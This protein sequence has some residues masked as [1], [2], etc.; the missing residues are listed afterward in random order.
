MKK[1][2]S[3]QDIHLL[4]GV[5]PPKEMTTYWIT[6]SKGE[7]QLMK[8]WTKDLKKDDSVYIGDEDKSW[9]IIEIFE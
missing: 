4:T 7:K 6:N 3:F 1:V 2:N 8:S 5:L 9:K